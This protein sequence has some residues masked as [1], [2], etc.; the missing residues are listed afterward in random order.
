MDIIFLKLIYKF[1]SAI[2]EIFPSTKNLSFIEI[3]ILLTIILSAIVALFSSINKL[4]NKKTIRDGF[5]Q[6]M[7]SFLG[8]L[9][10]AVTGTSISLLL[11]FI[12]YLIIP[13][14]SDFISYD[15]FY[16][17]H[18]IVFLLFGWLIGVL[19]GGIITIKPFST[20]LYHTQRELKNI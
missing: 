11:G 1:I 14:Q 13:A 18:L 9:L 4:F 5:N 6:F 7:Y 20:S 19:A 12:V 8:G 16:L 15:I 17:F 2:G 3:V 10:G